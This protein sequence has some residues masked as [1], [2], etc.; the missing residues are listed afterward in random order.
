MPSPC[1]HLLMSSLKTAMLVGVK[2]YVIV[3]LMFI[4][5]LINDVQYFMFMGYLRIFFEGMCTQ[6]FCPF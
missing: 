3:V 1:P 2:W 5:L 6:I 4:S